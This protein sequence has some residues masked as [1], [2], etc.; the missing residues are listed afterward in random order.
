MLLAPVRASEPYLKPFHEPCQNKTWRRL[1]L[2]AGLA[3]FGV[4]LLKSGPGARSSQRHWHAH[5]DEFR[6]GAVSRR[7]SLDYPTRSLAR[8]FCLRVNCS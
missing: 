7:G 2:A 4:N 6:P 1:G 8:V 3:Q 5:E